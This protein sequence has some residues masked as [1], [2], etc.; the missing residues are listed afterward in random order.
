MKSWNRSLL[1]L[2]ISSALT[3]CT[4]AVTPVISK[5]IKSDAAIIGGKEVQENDT[6]SKSVVG[7]LIQNNNTGE[8]EVCSGTLLKDNLILTAAHCVFDP[9]NGLSISVIFDRVIDPSGK[10]TTT[11][12]RTVTRSAIPAWWGAEDHLD[13]DTGD[14]ALLQF[15]GDIP[16][17]Y[18]PVT[19]LA[20]E[21]DI[22]NGKEVVIAG[23]GVNKVTKTAIDVN[24]YPDLI[25]S[26][27][28]GQVVCQ[29]SVRLL[30]CS[31]VKLEGAGV[32]RK[33]SAL[34]KNTRFSS[35]EIEVAPKSG[36]TCHGDS[37]GPAFIV[38]NNKLYLWGVANRSANNR[39]SD[40]S[41]NSVYANV[42]FFRQWLNLAA[43]KLKE[44]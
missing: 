5:K 31:E 8:V 41:V 28:S 3:A 15:T 30:N 25:G 4:Q 20:S 19:A 11:E 34:V 40:C 17:G 29:D 38:K 42:A 27:Q 1:F 43:S 14:I 23:Y 6:I 39:I 10:A 37:G 9:E 13:T 32:L 21:D 12:L 7:L 22:A 44:Q 24:T 2:A 26:I 16:K 36:I 35:S 33:A 18:S